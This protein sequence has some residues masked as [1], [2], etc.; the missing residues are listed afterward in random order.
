LSVPA[1]EDWASTWKL[2]PEAQP[3]DELQVTLPPEPVHVSPPVADEQLPTMVPEGL[4]AEVVIVVFWGSVEVKVS[5]QVLLLG[6]GAGC[7]QLA[8]GA[9]AGFGKV[10]RL[11]S[12]KL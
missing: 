11:L 5:V 3:E 8:V 4:V 2:A 10:A 1:L 9:V 12:A 7:V 6:T